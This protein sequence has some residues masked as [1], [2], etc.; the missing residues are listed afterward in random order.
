MAICWLERQ[1]DVYKRQVHTRGVSGSNPLT[2]TIWRV[3][4]VAELTSLSR[5]HSGVRI[6]Y[7]SPIKKDVFQSRLFLLVLWILSRKKNRLLR[8]GI[9]MKKIRE[10]EYL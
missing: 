1:K 8:Y 2:A 7:A 9:T 5:W 4:E 6:P 3:G 10:T